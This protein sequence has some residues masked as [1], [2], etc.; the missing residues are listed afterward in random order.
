MGDDALLDDVG[1]VVHII[2]RDV[3]LV[4]G[5]DPVKLFQR[6]DSDGIAGSVFTRETTVGIFDED[7][8][9]NMLL[10]DGL[11]DGLGL[12][13]CGLI[14]DNYLGIGNPV[15]AELEEQTLAEGILLIKVPKDGDVDTIEPGQVE[16]LEGSD[17]M[18]DAI[19]CYEKYARNTCGMLGLVGGN[20]HDE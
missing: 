3:T 5:I 8:T 6:I 2:D 14:K 11:V 20:G 9:L 18:H 1:D 15:D 17:A 19:F 4:L 10:E 12:R 7:G 16:T 13:S